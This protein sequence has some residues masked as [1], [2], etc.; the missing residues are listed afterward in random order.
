MTTKPQFIHVTTQLST[1]AGELKN[2]TVRLKVAHIVYY[3]GTTYDGSPASHRHT[4]ITMSDGHVVHATE[5]PEQID[6]D[7]EG[8]TPR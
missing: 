5:T 4:R 2:R 6:A 8:I 1:G 3:L 7:L